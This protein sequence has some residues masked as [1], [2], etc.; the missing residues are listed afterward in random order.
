MSTWIDV[1]HHFVTPR[2]VEA[3]CRIGITQVGGRPFPNV[4][5][6]DSIDAM[7][8]CGIAAAVGSLMPPGLAFFD[9]AT[10]AEM[11]RSVN[12]EAA[13]A[14][15]RHPDRLG[16][17]AALPLPHVDAAI[18]EAVRALD[19]LGADGVGLLSNARGVYLG[20][21]RF[22][23][24]FDEL[25]RRSAVV[26]EHPTFAIGTEVPIAPDAGSPLPGMPPAMIEFPF[27]T[28]RAIASLVS[29]GTMTRHPNIRF[30]FSHGGGTVPYLANRL[31]AHPGGIA[32]ILRR[33]EGASLD[34]LD[35]LSRTVRDETLAVLGALY[36]DT[37]GSATATVLDPLRALA[38]AS[39]ILVG[40]DL[41]FVPESSVQLYLRDLERYDGRWS[42]ELADNARRLFPRLALAP[43]S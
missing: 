28:T 34:E 10:A 25:D 4:T 8:R 2:Y 32:D 41:P 35:E 16:F 13:A 42:A 43:A 15:A 31:L 22:E 26:V 1:H 40:T 3:L 30:L 29:A 23:P 21:P 38:P 18:E 7:D 24:L 11:A 9:A 14:V 33:S 12:D 6:E 27:D 20:D 17:V 19:T 39:H 5:F 37:S 36:Y